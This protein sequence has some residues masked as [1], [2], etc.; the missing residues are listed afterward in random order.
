MKLE[1]C[2]EIRLWRALPAKENVIFVPKV[3]GIHVINVFKKGSIFVAESSLHWQVEKERS[4]LGSR[5]DQ[6]GYCRERSDK[7]Q[8]GSS[9][10]MKEREGKYIS[11]IESLWPVIDRNLM[12]NVYST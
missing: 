8:S 3:I 6:L 10:G 1:R 9:V 5:R 2:V 11:E 7:N 4:N 12:V